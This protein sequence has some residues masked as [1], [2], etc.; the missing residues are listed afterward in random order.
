MLA[1]CKTNFVSTQVLHDTWSPM[2]AI[3]KLTNSVVHAASAAVGIS[4][5]QYCIIHLIE[6]V[7][8]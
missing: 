4:V 6:E 7:I 1:T 5:G 2:T 8:M 3:N